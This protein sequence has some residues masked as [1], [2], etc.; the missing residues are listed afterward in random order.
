MKTAQW[1]FRGVGAALV[2][3]LAGCSSFQREWKKS[4]ER[5]LAGFE[6]RWDG[7]WESA[8]NHHSGRLRCIITRQT[9]EVFAA[10]FHA[11]YLGILSFGYTATL[12]TKPG[13]HPFN[14]SGSADLGSFAGGIYHYEG[15]ATQT[16]F[17]ST[18]SSKDDHGTFSMER[19]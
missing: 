11:K 19:R 7:R 1:I 17:F 12:E 9:N 4:A 2:L 13:M 5:P 16:N 14:F 6:G 10:R 3:T 15:H 8:K 18:Y